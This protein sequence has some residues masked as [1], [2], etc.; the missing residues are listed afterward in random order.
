M[1]K[2]S[3]LKRYKEGTFQKQAIST[4]GVDFITMPYK[5]EEGGQIMCKI[6]D[7]AGQERF[8]S[9]TTQLYSKAHGI[10]IVF[11]FDNME[12]FNGVR[13]WI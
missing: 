12:S 1:G 6:W 9:L 11:A 8:R 2:T 3:I 10:I 5:P 7:T 4:I 13:G